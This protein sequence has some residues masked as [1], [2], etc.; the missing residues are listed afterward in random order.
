MSSEYAITIPNDFDAREYIELNPDLANYPLPAAAKH[1]RDHGYNE[2]RKYTCPKTPWNFDPRCYRLLN[3]DLKDFTDAQTRAHYRCH[4]AFE[5]R[6]FLDPRRCPNTSDDVYYDKVARDLSVEKHRGFGVEIEERV[7][8]FLSRQ[9]KDTPSRRLLIV[10][11]DNSMQGANHY[12]YLMARELIR[13]RLVAPLLLFPGKVP[14]A[15]LERYGLT[16]CQTCDYED[17]AHILFR[18]LRRIQPPDLIYY[19]S[20][21]TSM[22][23]VLPHLPRDLLLLHS[24]EVPS[25][26]LCKDKYPPDF[27]VSETIADLWVAR[28]HARPLKVPP[29]ICDDSRARILREAKSRVETPLLSG[30]GLVLYAATPLVVMC[31]SLS[32]RKNFHVF[33]QV[34]ELCPS[35]NFMWIGGVST[36]DCFKL[37]NLCHIKHQDNPYKY[38]ALASLFVLTS[39]VDPCPYVVLESILLGIPVVTFSGSIFTDH[40]NHGLKYTEVPGPV[41]RDGLVR[42]CMLYCKSGDTRLVRDFKEANLDYLRKFY[43]TPSFSD[44]LSHQVDCDGKRVSNGLR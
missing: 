10:L 11:H 25:H 9:N 36:P 4:G 44:I 33:A 26:Y 7:E 19:N 13:Q 3:Y 35:L 18:F 15:T 43:D 42:A 12:A 17:D 40:T 23:R 20:I 30:T 34:A 14:G 6:P 37:P 31:G 39:D 28:G 2:G 5:Q 29:F 8:T 22:T 32:L 27:C 16:S 1:Y 38:M 21:N 41:T 24:H